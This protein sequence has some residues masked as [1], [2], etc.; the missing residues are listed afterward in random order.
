MSM[1]IKEHWL[2]HSL[3]GVKP[4]DVDEVVVSVEPLYL[5]H[6]YVFVV[7]TVFF[8]SLKAPHTLS[9]TT[10]IDSREPRAIGYR[11]LA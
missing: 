7:G 9:F 4:S 8:W 1:S 10:R 5:G 2:V 11:Y 6:V 3:A